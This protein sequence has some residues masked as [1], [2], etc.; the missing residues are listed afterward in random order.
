MTPELRDRYALLQ[1]CRN[2]S[3]LFCPPFRRF[4]IFLNEERLAKQDYVFSQVLSFTSGELA[5]DRVFAG[6]FQRIVGAFLQ[7]DVEWIPDVPRFLR[8]TLEFAIAHVDI[9][10][11]QQLLWQFPMDF[12]GDLCAV[13]RPEDAIEGLAPSVGF[14]TIV[15][16]GAA[17][18]CA[19]IR[20]ILMRFPE[21]DLR[22]SKRA[23][24][25]E[26]MSRTSVL[27]RERRPFCL[28]SQLRKKPDSGQWTPP[29]NYGRRVA[30]MG[31]EVPEEI[32]EA[33]TALGQAQTRAYLL[34]AAIQ[35]MVSDSFEFAADFRQ[36]PRL[37][38]LLFICGVYADSHSIVAPAAFALLETMV[39][40]N[41]AK[42][43]PPPGE[44]V[45]QMIA[46]MTAEFAPDMEFTTDL[47]PKMV[48]AF[49]LFWKCPIGCAKKIESEMIEFELL[50]PIDAAD[51]P[52]A[53]FPKWR[54]QRGTR[55]TPLTL[56]GRFLVDEPPLGFA[57]G[58]RIL[59]V[60]RAYE[61]DSDKVRD[62]LPPGSITH[63]DYFEYQKRVLDRD[64]VFYEFLTTKFPF[65]EDGDLVDLSIV[66]RVFPLSP[67]SEHFQDQGVP[68]HRA[69]LNGALIDFAEF[70]VKSRFFQF[71]GEPSQLFDIAPC[72][73]ELTAQEILEYT[74]LFTTPVEVAAE[75]ELSA[76]SA[77]RAPNKDACDPQ[78]QKEEP[79]PS[80]DL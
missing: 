3:A 76:D 53:V 31:L 68:M 47:T 17:R 34:I 8:S 20:R 56:Y 37:I 32:G 14:L 55:P 60:L 48:A 61:R 46:K 73:E 75:W 64:W 57:I 45:A 4:W 26:L 65:G 59:K 49:P 29:E 2:A 9:L 70:W 16:E 67:T 38:E 13:G 25:C 44:G 74:R 22:E 24:A 18:E 69:I 58:A 7:I 23:V 51:A 71:Q 5:L 15:M 41:E 12:G 63:N 21:L 19:T 66:A 54:G 40:G 11:Y 72:P 52:P 33:K 28:P 35:G 1:P 80:V 39:Y 30:G 27:T 43:V 79:D 10:A 78:G 62:A 50:P 77:G 6:H 36:S 42:G